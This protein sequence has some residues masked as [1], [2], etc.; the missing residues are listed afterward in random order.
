[1][2]DKDPTR[3]MT[4]YKGF[5]QRKAQKIDDFLHDHPDLNSE[6]IQ[7]LKDLNSTLKAQLER[8][9]TAWESMMS[10]LEPATYA[11]LDKMF[12]EV[13]EEVEKMLTASKKVISDKATSTQ[14]ATEITSLTRNRNLKGHT[15]ASTIPPITYPHPI[16]H[17]HTHTHCIHG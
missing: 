4:A 11:A 6:D 14:P 15:L 1:M 12:N 9:E 8:M 7:E 16:T 17:T 10:E 3:S 2:P 13:S 5:C